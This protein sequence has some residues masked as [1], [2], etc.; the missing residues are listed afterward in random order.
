MLKM[1]DFRFVF[2]YS[3]YPMNHPL[4]KQIKQIKQ[5]LINFFLCTRFFAKI[6]RAIWHTKTLARKTKTHIQSRNKQKHCFLLFI[7]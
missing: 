7:I 5:I 1:N 6:V 2:K 3:I 4:M